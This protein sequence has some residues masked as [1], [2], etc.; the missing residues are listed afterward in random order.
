MTEQDLTQHRSK[1]AVLDDDI[2]R[3]LVERFELTDEV[4]RIKKQNNMPVE[5]KEIEAKILSRLSETLD[6]KPSKDSI[7]NVYR[8]IFVESKE[9]QKKV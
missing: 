1:I 5:N 8:A 9:R 7:L 2:L 3:L 4:G 6:T